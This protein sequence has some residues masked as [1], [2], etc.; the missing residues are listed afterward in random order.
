MYLISSYLKLAGG[1]FVPLFTICKPKICTG[2]YSLFGRLFLSKKRTD[3]LETLPCSSMETEGIKV[4]MKKWRGKE[5]VETEKENFMGKRMAGGG[6]GKKRGTFPSHPSRLAPLSLSLS[7]SLSPY[8]LFSSSSL[9]IPRFPN[10]FLYP[11]L[12]VIL[13]NKC[14]TIDH[15][16]CMTQ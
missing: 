8:L 3:F 13:I 9:K 1:C 2:S 14:G 6:D 15:I 12:Y 4:K 11:Q 16:H 10:G 5:K 7:L